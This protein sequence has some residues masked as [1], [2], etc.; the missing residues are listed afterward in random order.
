ML[1]YDNAGSAK[2]FR[3]NHD[4]SGLP[5]SSAVPLHIRSISSLLWIDND[6][7]AIGASS[8]QLLDED[9]DARAGKKFPGRAKIKLP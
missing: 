5:R 1:Q 8:W 6:R 7:T 9:V 3:L 2:N 4:I